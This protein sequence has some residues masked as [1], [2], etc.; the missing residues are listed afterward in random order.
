MLLVSWRSSTWQ[1]RVPDALSTHHSEDS[2]SWTAIQAKR[3]YGPP[4]LTLRPRLRLNR[5]SSWVSVVKTRNPFLCVLNHNVSCHP[6]TPKYNS[7]SNNAMRQSLL[8]LFIAVSTC[9]NPL[10]EHQYA[11]E[12]FSPRT[13]TTALPIGTRF[14]VPLRFGGMI[15]MS[16]SA[17]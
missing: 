1:T 15:T 5:G 17:L 10:L 3:N 13:L 14:L 16:E 2:N 7:V 8:Y 12:K 9:S 4:Y 11:L 6:T